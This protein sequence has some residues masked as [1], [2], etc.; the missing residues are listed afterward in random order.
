MCS[1]IFSPS[2]SPPLALIQN[3]L[4]TAIRSHLSASNAAIRDTVRLWSLFLLLVLLVIIPIILDH[5]QKLRASVSKLHIKACS[6]LR[7]AVLLFLYR[8]GIFEHNLLRT[9][10]NFPWGVNGTEWR[11]R[12]DAFLCNL[13]VLWLYQILWALLSTKWFSL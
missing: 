2:S 10:S 11:N 8:L 1:D 5:E 9:T 3:V 13:S 7:L 4:V 12:Q 6:S